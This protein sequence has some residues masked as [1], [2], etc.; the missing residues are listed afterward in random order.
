MINP[1][2]E[3]YASDSTDESLIRSS[4]AGSREAL[5]KLIRRH[6]AW[7]Y[8]I[9]LRMVWNPQDA[10]D[11][12]QEVLIKVITKL[13]TFKGKSAFR[14]WLYRIVSNH[15]INMKKCRTER[16]ITNF[17]CYGK[18]LDQTPDMNLPDKNSVPV[19][20]QVLVEE[21]KIGCM[22]GM[23]L[24]LDRKQRFIYI[25]GEIFDVSGAV[26]SE[27]LGI[28]KD[29][30]RQKL[31]RTR[32]Q[33]HNFMNEKCGLIDKNNPCNCARKTK[34]FIQSGIV[35]PNELKFNKSYL[36]KV[37]EV[38]KHKAR[39]FDDMID[40]EPASFFREHPFQNSPDFTKLLQEMSGNED[41]REIL[42]HKCEIN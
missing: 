5:D 3:K 40:S 4:L 13:S 37:R 30:F 20:I 26:G 29:N 12:T 31:S 6:Q 14:T 7:I 18:T 33:L 24:C 19:E 23:L 42:N 10:E 36:E 25:L 17:D 41:F 21:A 2:T 27:I 1:F 9:A 32:R 22:T 16:M 39:T 8:N 15:V 28:N 11:V 35:D 34:G 38:A